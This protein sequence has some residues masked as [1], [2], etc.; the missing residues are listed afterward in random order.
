MLALDMVSHHNP[1]QWQNVLYYCLNVV[2]SYDC[3]DVEKV[4][5]SLHCLLEYGLTVS[6]GMFLYYYLL[7]GRF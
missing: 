3:S 6:V 1:R 4:T 7:L 5:Q 2:V